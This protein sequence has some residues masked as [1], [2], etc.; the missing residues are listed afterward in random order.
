MFGQTVVLLHDITNVDVIISI[1]KVDE[2]FNIF[3]GCQYSKTNCLYQIC[4]GQC[5]TSHRMIG[6]QEGMN[7]SVTHN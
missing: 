5:W 6:V 4:V 7:S 2:I 3:Y 1:Y